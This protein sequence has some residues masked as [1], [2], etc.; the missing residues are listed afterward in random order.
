MPARRKSF[1]NPDFAGWFVS[2]VGAFAAEAG[3]VKIV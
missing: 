3:N 2:G 1:E